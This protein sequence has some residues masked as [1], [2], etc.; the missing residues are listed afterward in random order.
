M[1]TS[2]QVIDALNL[3][4]IR[5]NGEVDIRGLRHFEDM[6]RAVPTRVDLLV[7]GEP[8]TRITASARQLRA[9]A[10]QELVLSPTSKRV[11]LADTDMHYG[12]ARMYSMSATP[13]DDSVHVCKSLP[14]VAA[15]LG[16]KLSDLETALS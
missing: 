1:S 7:I 13:A 6:L 4:V 16:V 2:F 12:L 5:L 15:L 11:I 14:E 8:G 3:A 9:F 10:S